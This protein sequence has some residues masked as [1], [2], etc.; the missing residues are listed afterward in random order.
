MMQDIKSILFDSC[1]SYIQNRIKT[2][3]QALH[4]NREALV[5]DS[6]SSAGDKFETTR[7][8]LQQEII[9]NESLLQEATNMQNAIDQIDINQPFINIQNGCVVET[10]LGM[11]FFAI[12]IGR[13][14]HQNTDYFII[15]SNWP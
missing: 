5:Q 3:E 7:E 9:R 13:L 4:N 2:A 1:K 15:S 10:N 6:K 11:F 14:T 12:A 8:M